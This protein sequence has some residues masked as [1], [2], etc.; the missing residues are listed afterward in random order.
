M[1]PFARVIDKRSWTQLRHS[2][3]GLFGHN[4]RLALV[5][6]ALLLRSLYRWKQALAV[7]WPVMRLTRPLEHRVAARRRAHVP[8]R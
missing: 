8:H 5:A 1:Q 6:A 4:R 7:L 2:F 3:A